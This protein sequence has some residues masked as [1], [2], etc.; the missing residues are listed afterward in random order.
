VLRSRREA[1]DRALA[2]AF[3]RT[4]PA[5]SSAS[6]GAGWRSGRSAAE[7]AGLG[8]RGIGSGRRALGSG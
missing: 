8:Q 6:S 4:R 5:R 3:P 7:R 1:V 2:E